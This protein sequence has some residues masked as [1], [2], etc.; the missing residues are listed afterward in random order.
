M[1]IELSLIDVGGIE[2]RVSIFQKRKPIFFSVIRALAASGRE[3]QH[4]DRTT[5]S[6]L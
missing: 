2:W 4:L 1:M 3:S 6:P 5:N